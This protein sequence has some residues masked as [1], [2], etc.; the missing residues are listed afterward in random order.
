MEAKCILYDMVDPDPSVIEIDDWHNVAQQME[1]RD[2]LG[3]TGHR[4]GFVTTLTS[5]NL[6]IGF[7]AHEGKKKGIQYD[8]DKNE[9]DAS[10]DAFEHLFFAIFPDT[11]QILIQHRYI[12][13]YVD[14]GLPVMRDGF[15]TALTVL[16]RLE[17]R[18]VASKNVQIKPAGRT[19]TQ[20]EMYKI[21][22]QNSVFQVKIKN[23]DFAKIPD[24]EK[25]SYKLY[26]PKEEANPITWFSVA[27]TLK[28]GTKKVEFESDDESGASK[29]NEGPLTKA[30]S[31]IGEINEL[32]AVND[33]GNIIIRKKESDK[34]ISITLPS[35]P[36][37]TEQIIKQVLANFDSEDRVQ[38][39]KERME[40]RAEDQQSNT[41]FDS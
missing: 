26:N 31:R 6:I 9:Y 41:L 37:V 29:L 20:E 30:F 1:A 15:L 27:E 19:Y 38:S 16:F 39:W 35:T 36:E 23:L 8:K 2:W 40:I 14:L 3:K 34:E 25:P 5:N 33:K 7:Y 4:F 24:P 32:K 10:T 18:G 12:Y 28:V 21:F 13:G 17:G 22:E 11:S